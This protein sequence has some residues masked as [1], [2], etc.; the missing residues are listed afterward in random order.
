M[1]LAA[2]ITV[3]EVARMV[4]ELGLVDPSEPER[5]MDQEVFDETLEYFGYSDREALLGLLD[6]LGIRYAYDYKAFRGINR[7]DD[8]AREIWYAEELQRIAACTRGLITITNVALRPD[9][10]EFDCNGNRVSWPVYPGD[11]EAVEASLVFAT[12]T[13]GLV[14][15]GSSARWCTVEPVDEDFSAELVFGDPVAL[16]Q[17]GE[18]FGVT[19][20]AD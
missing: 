10:L 20:S 3:R 9:S 13:F 5:R 6:D 4:V 19:F 11:D 7:V 17:L 16:G 1:G 12:Y 8:D 2:E 15:V 14:A 18:R